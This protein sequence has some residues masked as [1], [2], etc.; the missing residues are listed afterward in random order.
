MMMMTMTRRI[1]PIG[2]S[3]GDQW[4]NNNIDYIGHTS[5]QSCMIHSTCSR[6]FYVFIYT[7]LEFFQIHHEYPHL[8]Q[9]LSMHQSLHSLTDMHMPSVTHSVLFM[10]QNNDGKI[11]THGDDDAITIHH[12][13]HGDGTYLPGQVHSEIHPMTW[14]MCVL[15][16]REWMF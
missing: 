15:V 1:D 14:R 13:H 10:K 16:Q 11:K 2:T 7:I 8:R 6:T 3:F 9:H 4:H 5:I 12:H